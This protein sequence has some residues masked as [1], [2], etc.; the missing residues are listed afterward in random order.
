MKKKYITCFSGIVLLFIVLYAY[1]PIGFS[2]KDSVRISLH[3]LIS[4]SRKGEG[5]FQKVELFISDKGMKSLEKSR[6]QAI[7]RGCMLD[8]FQKKAKGVLIL[9]GKEFPVKVK[10]KGSLPSHWIEPLEWSFRVAS[11]KN[12][13]V[14]EDLRIFSLQSRNQR[15]VFADYYY[16]KVLKHYNIMHLKYKYIEFY[17]NGMYLENYTVEEFF[18]YPVIVKNNREKGIIFK[19]NS[20][21]FWINKSPKTSSIQESFHNHQE[22]YKTAP[23]KI[24]KDK[25]QSNL[26]RKIDSLKVD[27]LVQGFREKRFLANKVF[28][29]DVW[30]KYFAVNT[31]FANNHPALLTNLRFFYNEITNLIEPIGYDLEHINDLE[32]IEPYTDNFWIHLD[33][34]QVHIF[35]RHMFDDNLMHLAYEK[36]LSMLVSSSD[37]DS[38]LNSL[39]KETDLLI[40]SEKDSVESRYYI[41]KNLN[42][43]SKMLKNKVD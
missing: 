17:L 33:I 30:G 20:D 2:L 25:Y 24:Y 36:A 15:G 34:E 21:D 42:F 1:R 11:T 32:D 4:H 14:F 3:R 7:K 9:N 39:E 43:I 37:L 27:S 8:E 38:L 26:N 23:L 31:L 29:L 13:P 28:D 6:V 22:I 5:T 19:F 41:K 18:D 35:Y 40:S 12:I 10:L 16:H